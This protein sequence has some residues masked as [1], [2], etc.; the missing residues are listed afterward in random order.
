M[1][2]MK[3]Y[4]IE[5]RMLSILHYCVQCTFIV[6]FFSQIHNNL[7]RIPVQQCHTILQHHKLVSQHHILLPPTIVLHNH[8]HLILAQHLTQQMEQTLQQWELHNPPVSVNN[9][10]IMDWSSRKYKRMYVIL[11]DVLKVDEIYMCYS[12]QIV[13][14]YARSP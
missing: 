14:T 3:K 9:C 4:I 10:I 7:Q 2:F 12:V 6:G 13:L 11:I 5:F 8:I 1:I